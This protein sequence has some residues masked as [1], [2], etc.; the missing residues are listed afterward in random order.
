LG[1]PIGSPI[2]GGVGSNNRCQGYE[3]IN[4]N[5]TREKEKDGS[6]IAFPPVCTPHLLAH[7]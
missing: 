2:L 3:R 1:I 5:K 4:N 7:S 6:R